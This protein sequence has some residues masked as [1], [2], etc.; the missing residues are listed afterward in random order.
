MASKDDPCCA[1][2]IGLAVGLGLLYSGIQ[3]YLLLQKI[4]NTP[5]SKV[6]SAAVG[7]VELSGKA[8]CREPQL[9][10]ISGA[11]CIYWKIHEEY[12]QPGKHGGWRTTS[13]NFSHKD[14]YLEDDT[15]KM[16]VDPK[17]ATIEIPSD[18]TST[19]H[20]SSKGLL[21]IVPQRQLDPKVLAYLEGNPDAKGRAYRWSGYELRFTEWFIAEG[22]P[23]YV[24]GNAEPQEGASSAIGFENLVVRQ[25]KYD[26]VFYISD[27]GERKVVDSIRGSLYWQLGIGFVLAA[28]CGYYIIY[29][30]TGGT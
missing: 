8:L 1:A 23:L 12:Y 21:G 17:D 19:G 20:L 5:T 25:G 14:F 16:L 6:R 7:L 29:R 3:R 15:G 30:M 11:K 22:D 26:K 9:S 18:F 28:I 24:L 2:V 4:N 13:S 10:P 27:S